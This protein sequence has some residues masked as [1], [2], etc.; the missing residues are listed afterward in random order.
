MPPT[1]RTL[2]EEG[3]QI[4]SFKVV[5]K[6]EY[7]REELVRI[8]VDE[9]AQYEGCSGTRCLNDV[10]SDLRAQIASNNKGV[11]LINL[12]I[13][14]YGLETVLSY[15]DFIRSN[16][17]LAV[18]NLLKEVAERHG[19]TELH[20]IDH[21]DDGTPIELS[22]T[23][24]KEAGSAVFDFEGTGKEIFGNLNAPVSV[25]CT[26]LTPLRHLLARADHAL[27]TLADSTII[28][29]LRAMVDQDV[30]RL[31]SPSLSPRAS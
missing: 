29:C 12:L 2:F 28:Y 27:R 17:E 20:A 22:V 13:D 21:L 6:G 31:A 9:P 5:D 3:A 8:L 7:Q 25:T 15:M 19:K 24:D 10:E 18:R 26:L 14:E 4:I 16:A 23:I 11:H 1:S 30:S